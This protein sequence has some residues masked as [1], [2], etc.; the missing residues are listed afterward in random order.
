MVVDSDA[1]L[2]TAPA[3][4]AGLAVCL[5]PH[6]LRQSVSTGMGRDVPYRDLTVWRKAMEGRGGEGRGGEGRGGEGL[7]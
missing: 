3:H 7:C 2:L 6:H 1:D 5:D 4:K